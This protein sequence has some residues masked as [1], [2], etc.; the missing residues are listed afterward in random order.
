M[1]CDTAF[2]L[3][4]DAET[5]RSSALARHLEGC[6]RCRQM[7]ETLSPA[8]RFLTR[9]DQDDSPWDF[10]ATLDEE[11]RGGGR[12]PIVTI[13]A[14]KIAE[15]AATGLAAKCE[16]RREH[17][18]RLVG[19]D[20]RY[21]AV[22]AAGLLLAVTLFDSTT[23]DSRIPIEEKCTRREASRIDIERSAVAIRALA[24]S[25]SACHGAAPSLIERHATSL[26]SRGVGA[27]DWVRLLLADETL[28][29]T[30]QSRAGMRSA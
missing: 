24:L 27:F 18:Q 15:Q 4:T 23:H 19:S 5:T 9:N 25:C 3:M 13:K 30:R 21:A 22:F 7:Q 29:A 10:T 11:T 12:Q 6:P 1:N 8:L 2:D 26:E 17:M 20:L 14:L 16:T 28:L